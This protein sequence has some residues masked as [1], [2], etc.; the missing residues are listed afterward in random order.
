MIDIFLRFARR[1]ELSLRYAQGMVAA[2]NHVQKVWR[3]HVGPNAL[4]QIQR[5]QRV[6]RA[7]HKEDGRGQRTQ[8]FVAKFCA[9]TQGAKRISKTNQAV[10]FFRPARM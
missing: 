5:T 7:L 8:N 3:F 4:Q 1:L 6:A 2:L 10:D 9:I